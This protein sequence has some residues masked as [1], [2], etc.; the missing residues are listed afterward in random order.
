MNLYDTRGA[1]MGDE[2]FL[3]R[4]TKW[5]YEKVQ[6]GAINILEAV[7]CVWYHSFPSVTENSLTLLL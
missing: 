3:K 6:A 1:E 2:E 5:F 7:H 4:L